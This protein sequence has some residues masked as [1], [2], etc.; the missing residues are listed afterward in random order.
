M[1]TARD[2][3]IAAV[4][5]DPRGKAGVA[6]KLGVSR[7]LLSRVLSAADR[8]NFSAALAERVMA[9]YGEV[10]ICPASDMPLD[11]ER[12]RAFVGRPAPTHNPQAMRVWKCCQ[13]CPHRPT[14]GEKK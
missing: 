8:L 4:T 11:R 12:C 5:D 6:E 9:V 14:S 7:P 3:L 1:K 13:R 10:Q 2:L